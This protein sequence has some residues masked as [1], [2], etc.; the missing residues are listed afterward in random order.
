MVPTWTI[1]K[2]LQWTT[3]YFRRHG[4]DQPRATAE[5]LLA[6]VLG[7]ERLGL[8]LHFD[9]PLHD[10][11]LARFRALIR[12]R[13]AREP[14][15][16]LTGR[17]EFWS[18]T[19]EV[20]PA[21]LIP[22]PET[23]L[24]VETALEFLADGRFSVLDLATGSG[25][26]VIALARERPSWALTATDLSPAALA[27][28]QRNARRHQVADHI[29]LAAMDLFS[30]WSERAPG[31][32]LIVTNPPYIGDDEFSG[33]QPEVGL[34]EPRGALLGGG[35]LGLDLI[36]KIL[37][38]APR[39]LRPGGR[40]L[41]EIGMGQD[42]HLE[43]LVAADLNYDAHGFRKDYAG[44]TRLLWARTAAPEATG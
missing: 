41:L 39:R 33:L 5:I 2:V 31:F 42:Q 20:T 37:A 14:T 13:A 32:D 34:F 17:Q 44:I 36:R 15:Q 26:I 24:L 25:A 19:L 22:R 7:M 38:A 6:S 27:V 1:L 29:A 23:E 12:R 3:D 43:S 40:L 18:L 30:G 8:Y 35:R 28:A 21:V 10:E 4:I 11:E 16:Y 9:Q